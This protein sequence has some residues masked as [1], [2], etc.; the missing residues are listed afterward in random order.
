MPK[1]TATWRLNQH[2]SGQ[3]VFSILAAP[4]DVNDLMDR[5]SCRLPLLTCLGSL[6]AAMLYDMEIPLMFQVDCL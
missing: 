2:S 5:S 1:V 6:H 4:V 3:D